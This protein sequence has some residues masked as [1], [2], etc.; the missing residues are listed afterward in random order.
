MISYFSFYRPVFMAQ[1]LIAEFLF[2]CRLKKRKLFW[3]RYAASCILCLLFALFVPLYPN[4]ALELSLI[5][6]AKIG[7]AH[8]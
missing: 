6:I 2:T 4:S 1:L 3:L 5:F 8:V 7:R